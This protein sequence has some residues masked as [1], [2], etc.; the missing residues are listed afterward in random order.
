MGE[1][2]DEG[3]RL[4]FVRVG[5]GVTENVGGGEESVFFGVVGE[6]DVADD[7][8]AEGHDLGEEGVL[9]G[10]GGEAAGDGE[11][12]G[13]GLA[14]VSDGNRREEIEEAFFAGAEAEIEQLRGRLVSGFEFWVLGCGEVEAV[15]DDGGFFWVEVLGVGEEFGGERDGEFGAAEEASR[16]D[17]FEGV[18]VVREPVA[19]ADGVPVKNELGK[20]RAAEEHHDPVA[21]ECGAF[22]GSGDVVEGHRTVTDAK[23]EGTEAGGEEREEFGEAGTTDVGGIAGE[24]DVDVVEFQVRRD[25]GEMVEEGLHHQALAVH[26]RGRV[27][28]DEEMLRRRGRHGREAP[29]FKV[30]A[31]EN[32]QIPNTDQLIGF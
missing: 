5:G 4:G 6:A 32:F 29:R 25:G 23:R 21:T 15:G 7:V 8:G 30:Q 19:E 27:S 22:G 9:I 1:G 28:E 13:V 26:G 31:P 10:D 11:A 24:A 14:A 2:F 16:E 3:E 17:A 20:E 12:Q 18:G